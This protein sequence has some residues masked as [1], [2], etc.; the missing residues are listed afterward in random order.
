MTITNKKLLKN[1]KS[2]LSSSV[3]A[4]EILTSELEKIDEKYR[5][6]AEAEK[7]DIAE[8][9]AILDDQI[10]LYSAL[11]T[12]TTQENVVEETVSAEEEA[13]VDTIYEDNNVEDSSEEDVTQQELDSLSEH[14]EESAGVATEDNIDDSAWADAF[15]DNLAT[16]EE[17]SDVAVEEVVEESAEETAATETTEKEDV[18]D[19]WPMPEDWK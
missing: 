6:L 18:S 7:S 8:Q 4:K 1:F 13:V 11:L 19:E 12:D 9:M 10:K 5:K 2:I 16:E 17:S 3:S 15:G 14:L